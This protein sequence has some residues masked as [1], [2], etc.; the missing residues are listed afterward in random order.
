LIDNLKLNNKYEEKDIEKIFQEFDPNKTGEVYFND[1]IKLI[2][3]KSQDSKESTYANFYLSAINF[4]LTPSE[5]I[6]ETIKKA[7]REIAAFN[8]ESTT[9]KELEWV[10]NTLSENDLFDFRLKDEYIAKAEYEN[11]EILK[12]LS[13]YSHDG[14]KRQKLD[15]LDFINTISKKKK[16]KHDCII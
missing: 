16:K 15:D 4:F 5:R 14:I 3:E 6:T 9:I 10:I 7:I 1:F 12:F 8:S 13:E 2:L 11:N